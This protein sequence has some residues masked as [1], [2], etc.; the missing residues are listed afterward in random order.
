MNYRKEIIFC[1]N[2]K[3]QKIYG[4]AFIPNSKGKFPLII[5]SHGYGY[6]GSFVD[7]KR[8]SSNGIAVYQFDFCGGSNYSRSQGKSTEMTVLTEADDLESVLD[9]MKKQDF[10]DINK[11]Y[12]SGGSQGGLISILVGERRQKEIKGL[13]LY[14][15]GLAILD[16]YE[17]HMKTKT[18]NES[19]RLI[20]MMIT[21]KYFDDVEKLDVYNIIKNIKIPFL[22]YHGDMDECVNVKYA[23]KA[24]KYFNEKAK[25]II[26][27][28]TSHM[29][30]YGN[31]DLLFNDIINFIFKNKI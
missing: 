4:E 14:C 10:V 9:E 30:F 1:R 8:L 5:F 11:I 26:L 20:N 12:L 19:F 25:L 15:A 16:Y 22:Y 6:N 28:N 27:K 18:D 21:R 13:I 7:S 17:P 3:N 31:E 29:L 23:Y 24:Q 2:K